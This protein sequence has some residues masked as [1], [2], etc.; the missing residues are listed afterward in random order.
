MTGCYP[1]HRTFATAAPAFNFRAALESKS[2]EFVAGFCVWCEARG[3]IFEAKL[4]VAFVIRN[5]AKAGKEFGNGDVVSVVAKPY[6]FSSLNATDPNYHTAL[7]FLREPQVFEPTLGWQDCYYA[8]ELAMSPL[9]ALLDP[10]HG[11]LFYFDSRLKEPPKEWGAVKITAT[12]GN[13][14]FCAKV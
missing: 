3:A 2:P 8:A 11:A 10:T 6:A 13:L 4:G 7:D 1:A 12:L 14:T 9:D 5:R